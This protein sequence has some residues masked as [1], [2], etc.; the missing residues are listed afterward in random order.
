MTEELLAQVEAHA[1]SLGIDRLALI[2]DAIAGELAGKHPGNI[3][4]MPTFWIDLAGGIAAG[5]Q[6]ASDAPREPVKAA[7]PWP[8]D[9]F[10]LRVFGESMAPKI[11]DRALIVVRRLASG[12][13]PKKGSIV[14]YSDAHGLSLKVLDYRKARPGEEGNAFGQVAILR[15]I[16]PDY[17]EVQTMDGGRIEAVYIET[18]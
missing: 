9:H 10:A 15:S 14:V 5:A 12:Q 16:N 7:K 13:P 3:A 8:D 4:Q 6:I 11:P 18:L 1:A 17:P 2:R